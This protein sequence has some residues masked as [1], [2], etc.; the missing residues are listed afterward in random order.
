MFSHTIYVL[1]YCVRNGMPVGF[2]EG[3]NLKEHCVVLVVKWTFFSA[4][5]EILYRREV[6]GRTLHQERD[7]DG[8]PW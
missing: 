1:S 3:V 4:T 8:C 2:P 5:A 7:S 6:R